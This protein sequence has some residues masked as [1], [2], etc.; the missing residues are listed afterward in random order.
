MEYIENNISIFSEP[1]I[2]IRGLRYIINFVNYTNFQD[3][4]RNTLTGEWN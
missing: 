1:L 3:H 4:I 2:C